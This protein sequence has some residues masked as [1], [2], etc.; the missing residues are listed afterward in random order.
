VDGLIDPKTDKVVPV[1]ISA[2]IKGFQRLKQFLVIRCATRK[3][4]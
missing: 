1:M 2:Q 3:D 4:R